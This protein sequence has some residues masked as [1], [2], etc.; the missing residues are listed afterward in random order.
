M[1]E[2]ASKRFLY[3]GMA[4][5]TGG[6]ENDIPNPK[7]KNPAAV[8]LGRLGGLKGGRARADSLTPERRAE[9]AKKAAAKR[10][11]KG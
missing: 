10:W 4:K 2:R 1:L 9:I 8:A 11:H 3:L 5:T 7:E 6:K